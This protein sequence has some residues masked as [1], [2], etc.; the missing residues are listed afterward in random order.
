MHMMD[1]DP[2]D[3]EL[4]RRARDGDREALSDLVERERLRLF[5]LAYAELRHYDD[6]QDVVA[7]A[8]LRICRHVGDL[9]EPG[10][11]RAWMQSVVRNEARRR[12]RSRAAEPDTLPDTVS[13]PGDGSLSLLR[14]DVL[15]ALRRLP[16]DQAR[17]IAS[18]G[19]MA[20]WGGVAQIT[21][22]APHLHYGPGSRGPGSDARRT[23][24]SQMGEQTVRRVDAGRESVVCMTQSRS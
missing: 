21:P 24:P 7:A 14:L 5:A 10:R 1:H 6:A 22:G 3:Y 4:A 16:R 18:F 12:L 9:R 13:A 20:G 11:A 23:V 17:A 15:L 19:G 2:D 8:L